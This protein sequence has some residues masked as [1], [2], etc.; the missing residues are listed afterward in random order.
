PMSTSSLSDAH[1]V[2]S[3]GSEDRLD[4]RDA[5][6]DE[7]FTAGEVGIG[8]PQEQ[9]G[10]D[11]DHDIPRAT[12]DEGAVGAVGGVILGELGH[13]QAFFPM[14]NRMTGWS[15]AV[16]EDEDSRMGRPGCLPTYASS[17]PSLAA[18]M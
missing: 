5:E 15:L 16:L 14:V 8:Q 9:R 2:G 6:R 10:A 1:D 4:E 11:G 7:G 18:T 13:G 3:D 17:M 12:L